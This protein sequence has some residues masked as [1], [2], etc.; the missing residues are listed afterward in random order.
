MVVLIFLKIQGIEHFFIWKLAIYLICIYISFFG[1]IAIQI[2]YPFFFFVLLLSCSSSLH[3]LDAD[4]LLDTW[5][6]NIF[7]QSVAC[8]FIFLLDS[9]EEQKYL[10]IFLAKVLILVEFNFSIFKNR[11]IFCCHNSNSRSWEF[12]PLSSPR[13]FI[14]FALIFRFMICFELIFKYDTYGLS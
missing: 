13:C 11:L 12:S 8:P 1:E 9:F 3:V 4:P 7:S 14:V 2:A 6:R 10:G 5:F